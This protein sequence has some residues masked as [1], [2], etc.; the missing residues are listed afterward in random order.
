MR[1]NCRDLILSGTLL[2]YMPGLRLE[3]SE[4]SGGALLTLFDNKLGFGEKNLIIC[5]AARIH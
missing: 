1:P 2:D 3:L 4:K 5:L